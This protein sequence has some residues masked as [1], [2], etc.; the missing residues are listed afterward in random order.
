[1]SGCSSALVYSLS[2][3]LAMMTSRTNW[4]V[5]SLILSA[6]LTSSHWTTT[7][8]TTLTDTLDL[9]PKTLVS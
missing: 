5:I 2:S 8:G 1:M 9:Q 4:T 7:S 3:K 6:T